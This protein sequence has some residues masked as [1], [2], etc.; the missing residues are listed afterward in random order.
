MSVSQTHQSI[1]SRFWKR[2]DFAAVKMKSFLCAI[3]ISCLLV[4]V[5]AQACVEQ[6]ECDE[7]QC[8]AGI[9]FLGGTC[10]NFT[11]E[12][13][14]CH[15]EDKVVPIFGDFF[16]GPCPC[17]EGLVCVQQ[18]KKKNNGICQ[19]PA[20]TTAA[21]VTAD[22]ATDA[23]ADDSAADASVDESAAEQPAAAPVAK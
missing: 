17:A 7:T 23:S 14:K 5:S 10:Q 3:F 16:V 4:V 21:P 9:P 12:G 22:D 8:C 15:V 11:A 20:T 18:G 2:G 13:G 6:E 1:P 19:K